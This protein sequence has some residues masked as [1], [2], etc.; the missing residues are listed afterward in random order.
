MFGK[1]TAA[2]IMAV[3]TMASIPALA[4]STAN[5]TATGSVTIIRPITIT[6][7]ADLN[8]GRIV[9]SLTGTPTIAIANT[10]DTVSTGT[11]VA[12]SGITPSRAKFT[13]DGEGGQAISV[14][15]GT[16]TMTGPSASTLVVT[17][18]PDQSTGAVLSNA[19]GAAGS[20]TLNVGGSFPLPAAAATGLYSGTFTVTVAYN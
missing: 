1:L 17:L 20:L 11:A 13:I 14:A 4:Q 5:T 12:L 10:A 19:L 3:L 7:T 18:T 9:K 16:L 6:K 2:A 15:V 8:F